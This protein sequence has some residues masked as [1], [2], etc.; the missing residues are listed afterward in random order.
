MNEQKTDIMVFSLIFMERDWSKRDAFVLMDCDSAE[1]FDTQQRLATYVI[2]KKS[3]LSIRFTKDW[4]KY[5]C[6]ARIVTDMPNVMGKE[7]Y[8][9]FREN[10]HDQTVLSLL[11]KKYGIPAFRDPSQAGNNYKL[12]PA[13]VLA[14]SKYPQVIDSHRNPGLKHFYQLDYYCP[15][16]RFFR[17]IIRLCR[18][19]LRPFV[20]PLLIRLKIRSE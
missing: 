16:G 7:N 13:E 10:R 8:E 17:R 6:D 14:R 11:S 19:I 2:M 1:F 9:G 20:K 15:A 4:L 12:F 5:A 3:D 18:R